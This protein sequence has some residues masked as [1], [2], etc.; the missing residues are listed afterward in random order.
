MDEIS[1]S[2][3]ILIEQGRWMAKEIHSLRRDVRSL[4][5]FKWKAMGG[6]SLAA[7]LATLFIEWIRK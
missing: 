2:L 3:G 1:K 6:A 5:N 4:Q 7:F